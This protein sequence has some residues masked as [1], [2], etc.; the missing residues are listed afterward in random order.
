MP[1][2]TGKYT[3][4]EQRFIGALAVSGVPEY[5]RL[6]AGYRSKADVD[7]AKNP[8]IMAAVEA[9]RCE[10]IEKEAMPLAMAAH[11]ELLQAPT[12]PAVR[13]TMVKLTYEEHGKFLQD[14]ASDKDPAE[15]TS[16]EI[17]ERIRRFELLAAAKAVDVTPEEGIFG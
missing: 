9:L 10:F 7:K 5:A 11:L 6:K 15:M 14:G 1:S 13:A 12:P 16:E 2:K 3:E 17:A 8:A 4:Q